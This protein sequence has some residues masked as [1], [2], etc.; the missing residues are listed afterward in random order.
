MCIIVLH[1]VVDSETHSSVDDEWHDA[2]RSSFGE[3]YPA[4]AAATAA[5][6][7]VSSRAPVTQAAGVTAAAAVPDDDARARP[8]RRQPAT[9]TQRTFHMSRASETA[10]GEGTAA[11]STGSHQ[12]QG[13]LH[14]I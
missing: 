8:S 12:L 9:V 13:T 11:V 10:Q 3:S 7:G 14:I 6:A 2:T 4:A 5:C 1:Y